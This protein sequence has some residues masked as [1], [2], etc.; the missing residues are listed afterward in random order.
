MSA[1]CTRVVR[2]CSGLF[3]E[4]VPQ[5]HTANE[6]FELFARVFD[7]VHLKMEPERLD[8]DRALDVVVRICQITYPSLT[9]AQM[10]CC[11]TTTTTAN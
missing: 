4:M 10:C 8:A 6:M 2:S 5:L 7:I 3:A 11:C 9:T 1:P